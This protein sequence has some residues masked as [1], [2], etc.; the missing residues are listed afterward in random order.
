MQTGIKAQAPDGTRSLTPQAM[1]GAAGNWLL[2]TQEGILFLIVLLLCIFLTARSPVFL[3]QRNVGVLLSQVSMTAITAVGMTLLI[4]AGEVDLSVGSMQAFI[5]VIV[6][7]V[8]NQTASLPVGLIVGLALGPLLGA[9]N[10]LAP[11]GLG[12]NSFLVTL[13]IFPFIP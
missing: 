5:G 3:T 12:I 9:V 2:R 10:A 1:L 11:L 7:Q 13:P 6:M 4:I 8:L